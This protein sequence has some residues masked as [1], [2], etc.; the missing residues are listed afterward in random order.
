MDRDLTTSARMVAE[1]VRFRDGQIG[2]V[3]PPAA[4]EIFATDAHDE[5]AYAVFNDKGTLIAGFPGFD[6]PPMPAR[7]TG[8]QTF[9]TMFR[10][11]AMHGSNCASR[12]LPPM[13]W[14]RSWSPRARR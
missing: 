4:L 5:V 7:A 13:G 1:Q 6:P 10:T 14:R 11:E 9:D 3:V 12:S 8:L 2:V